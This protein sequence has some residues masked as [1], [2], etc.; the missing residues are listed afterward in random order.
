MTMM[1]HQFIFHFSRLEVPLLNTFIHFTEVPEE[2]YT[3]YGKSQK[4]ANFAL[5]GQKIAF[6]AVAAW[7]Q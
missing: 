6:M 5:L 3:T 1:E 4:S 7:Q 2:A